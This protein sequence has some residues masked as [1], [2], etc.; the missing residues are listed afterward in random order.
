[1][2][3]PLDSKNKECYISDI[4]CRKSEVTSGSLPPSGRQ[5]PDIFTQSSLIVSLSL[6]GALLCSATCDASFYP[7]R[8]FFCSSVESWGKSHNI[9]PLSQGGM[10]GDHT[11]RVPRGLPKRF[12]GH[13]SIHAG[14][15]HQGSAVNTEQSKPQHQSAIRGTCCTHGTSGTNHHSAGGKL[16]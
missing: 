2:K 11:H 8:L 14:S 3:L 6:P 9:K 7:G 10:Y 13:P 4:G 16:L 15:A 1:M 5:T 12:H